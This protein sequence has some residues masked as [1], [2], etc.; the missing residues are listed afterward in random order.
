VALHEIAGRLQGSSATAMDAIAAASAHGRRLIGRER[1][2]AI[3]AS[4]I[5]AW[6]A[7]AASGKCE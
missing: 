1:I 7:A 2:N 5:S 3:A 6:S 4:T